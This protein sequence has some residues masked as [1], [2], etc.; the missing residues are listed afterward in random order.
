MSIIM[1]A[2]TTGHSERTGNADEDCSSDDVA[3]RTKISAWLT[4]FGSR[5]NSVDCG[6]IP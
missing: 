1:N 3:R 5:R 6:L 2:R 4:A